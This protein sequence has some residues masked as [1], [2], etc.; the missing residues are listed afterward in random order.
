MNCASAE[1]EKK[2]LVSWGA[3]VRALTCILR[4]GA[5]EEEILEFLGKHPDVF[6]DPE[7]HLSYLFTEGFV[8]AQRD[9]FGNLRIKP[10]SLI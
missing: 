7:D 8:I 1:E 6:G 5:S 10:F 9:D 3:P 2:P 4:R